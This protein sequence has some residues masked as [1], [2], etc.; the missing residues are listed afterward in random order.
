[1]VVR[2]GI[3]GKGL[4]TLIQLRAEQHQPLPVFVCVCVCECV[5]VHVREKIVKKRFTRTYA[6]PHPHLHMCKRACIG[7]GCV[8]QNHAHTHTLARTCARR[9][10]RGRDGSR[11][12]IAA[13]EISALLAARG[14]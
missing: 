9:P 8:T 7:L 6:N 10:A 1:V 3:C 11:P 12:P 4:P 13:G 2:R 5:C 14:V